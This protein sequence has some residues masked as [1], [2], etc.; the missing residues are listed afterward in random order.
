MLLVVV[1]MVCMIFG[2]LLCCW[3]VMFS[4]IFRLVIV[5]NVCGCIEDVGVVELI[6]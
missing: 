2:K 1:V 3:V 5:G 4:F 6:V